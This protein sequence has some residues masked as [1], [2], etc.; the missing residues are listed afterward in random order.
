MVV[1][2]TGHTLQA[3]YGSGSTIGVDGTRYDLIQFHFHTPSEHTIDGEHAAAELHLVH[4]D[5]GNLAVVG[6]LVE[7]GAASEAVAPVLEDPPDAE[8]E[9]R[10][11]E[12]PVDAA[13]LLPEGHATFRYDGSLTTPPCSEGVRWMVMTEPVT[14]SAEQLTAF[15]DL[16]DGSNRP[17][18]PLHDRV[19]LLDSTE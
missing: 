8:G 15:T 4:Q 9:Q 12:T 16:Y 17:T 3:G 2:N 1:S 14:W 18:Q 7:E 10:E 19:E 5:D 11:P 13:G 6:V